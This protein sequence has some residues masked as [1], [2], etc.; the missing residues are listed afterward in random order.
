MSTTDYEYS[1]MSNISINTG[2]QLTGYQK[3]VTML[4]R[5]GIVYSLLRDL[6]LS[7]PKMDELD[8]LI[9][10]E[11][12]EKF[13]ALIKQEGFVLRKTLPKKAVYA[14]YRDRKLV[15]LDVHFAFIQ[16]GWEYMSMEGIAE[17]LQTT[18]QGFY[19]LSREDQ[20]LH[21]FFHNL[22]G[23]M[24][25][26]KKHLPM[27]Q[28][29]LAYPLDKEYIQSKL[30][31]S[32]IGHIFEDFCENPPKYCEN[33]DYAKKRTNI[34]L[35]E[36]KKQKVPYYQ[37]PKVQQKKAG[38]QFVFLGVDGAGKSTTIEY[39]QRILAEAGKLKVHFVYMGPWGYI[40]S[41]LLRLIYK[42]KFFPH[43]ENWGVEIR[44]KWHGQS[45]KYGYPAMLLKW[46][47]NQIKG[48]IYYL[49]VYQEMWYRH[50]KLVRPFLKRGCIVLCDRYI[51][52]LR[53]IYKK[54]P[55]RQFGFL[56]WAICKFFPKPDK[57]V[58]VWNDPDQIIARKPQLNKSE[59]I[60]FQEFYREVLRQ[61]PTLALQSNRS[62]MDIA[63][64]VVQEI[65]KIYLRPDHS[66]D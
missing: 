50:L 64:E 37:S 10:P 1:D 65:M 14:A 57:V 58:F 62:P 45:V 34:L 26:Q 25:L 49:A 39:V 52:D 27:V 28:M 47:A 15:L 63:D 16:N 40:Q 8:L 24:H 43:H 33:R 46:I 55:I 30:V 22:I 36:L 6:D 3:V 38:V 21:Y 13:T 7:D 4:H 11:S 66:G 20:L 61:V 60:L 32:R 19:A 56:R 35:S 5:A 9:F 12:R 23:K 44:K 54:R 18:P 41:P 51:Y 59:I 17:R 2:E 53:Y 42:L 31:S 48:T 29:L